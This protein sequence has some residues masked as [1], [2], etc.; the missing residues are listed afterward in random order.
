[1]PQGRGVASTPEFQQ[2]QC[3]P[4]PEH[5]ECPFSGRG[6]S[7]SAASRQRR[8]AER[9]GPCRR[10]R[11]RAG[12]RRASPGALLRPHLRPTCRGAGDG[13][14]RQLAGAVHVS[15]PAS[16]GPAARSL[17][18]RPGAAAG[19]TGRGAFPTLKVRAGP[20]L[21]PVAST[22]VPS[23]LLPVASWQLPGGRLHAGPGPA[24]LGASRRGRR[25][26]PGLGRLSHRWPLRR[27][28]PEAVQTTSLDSRIFGGVRFTPVAP[29][30]L[31][32]ARR[33][34]KHA[35]PGR[36]SLVPRRR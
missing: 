27:Q 5:L 30:G 7:G 36:S 15:S 8:A 6:C 32:A 12:R 13:A 21:P 2:S 10:G 35:G 1:M 25:Q 29:A 31:E 16:S 19:G 33:G 23:A 20:L 28:C 22:P 34:L 3:G 14:D 9:P 18:G 11:R 17:P 26:Y 4:G 24:P